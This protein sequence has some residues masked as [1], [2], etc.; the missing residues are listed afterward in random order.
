VAGRGCVQPVPDVA[1]TGQAHFGRKA[2]PTTPRAGPA[3]VKRTDRQQAGHKRTA[4]GRPGLCQPKPT[5]PSQESGLGLTG[6]TS[7]TT[8][9]PQESGLRGELRDRDRDDQRHVGVLD[10][11][12]VALADAEPLARPGLRQPRPT[13]D[14]PVRRKA[15][16]ADLTHVS[17]DRPPQESG[18]G[19][20]RPPGHHGTTLRSYPGALQRTGEPVCACEVRRLRAAGLPWLVARLV[21]GAAGAHGDLQRHAEVV[22]GAH[23]GSHQVLQG[24]QLARGHLEDQFVV[25]LEQHPRAQA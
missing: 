23:L 6:P 12:A 4:W 11:D 13:A 3:C 10:L 17:Q 25:D 18:L 21:P 14:E 16:W 5:S 22:G 20:R 8:G 2:L 19:F 1:G 24:G 7:A 9:A 15:A